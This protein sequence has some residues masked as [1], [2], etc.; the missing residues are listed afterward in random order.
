MID[1]AIVGGGLAGG[2][3]ALALY[4]KHPE[5]HIAVMESGETL[6]GNHRW[7]WFESD[8][9]AEGHDLLSALKQDEWNKGYDVIFPRHRRTLS[10][11]YRSMQS[12]DFHEGITQALPR[13]ALLLGRSAQQ[14][15]A[16]GV[17]LKDGERIEARTVIDCRPFASS[18]HLNG[19][20]QVFMGR[21]IRLDRPHGMDRPIIMDGAVDQHAPYGNGGAFRFVYTLP[22]GT[23]DVF[24]ED[25]YYADTPQLDQ[26]VLSA[27]ID[28]YCRQ[29][30]WDAG[31]TIGTESGLLPV[32]TGGDFTAHQAETSIAGVV[33][34][35][36]RGG[37]VHPLTSY[38]LPT[39]VENAL[40]IA[41]NAELSGPE[42]ATMFE[43]RAREHW[44]AMGYYRALGRTLFDAAKPHERYRIFQRFYGLRE[45][46]V[47]RFYAGRSTIFDKVRILVGRPPVAFGKALAALLGKG[48]P[49]VQGKPDERS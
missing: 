27:R 16:G 32:I 8:L 4:R 7:S 43:A 12:S 17:T 38:T 47:E 40:V 35:G 36:A 41:D 46:L 6:G 5:L 26:S 45:P 18:T 20:W 3:I 23:H 15:D 34:A 48:A 29:M 25:T 9:S 42:L 37:F 10:A 22:L 28:G 19:G 44:R 24:V 31:T 13:D 30:G 1:V 49:L 2:L 33:A 11:G 14:L 21:H 39:A